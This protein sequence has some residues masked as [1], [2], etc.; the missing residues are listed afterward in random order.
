MLLERIPMLG[1]FVVAAFELC[2]SSLEQPG[3]WAHIVQ[4]RAIPGSPWHCAQVARGLDEVVHSAR[5]LRTEQL[6]EILQ[7]LSNSI[8]LEARANR[9]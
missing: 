2:V 5:Q 6:I 3:V 1:D 4:Y 8:V 9:S 7:V